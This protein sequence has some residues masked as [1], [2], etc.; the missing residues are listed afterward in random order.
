MIV[1]TKKEILEKKVGLCKK[2]QFVCEDCHQTFIMQARSVIGTH[3]ESLDSPLLCQKCKTNRTRTEREGPDWAVK[4]TKKIFDKLKEE[5]GVSNIAQRPDVK[6]KIT[7]TFMERYGVDCVMKTEGFKEKTRAY[8]EENQE[9]ISEKIRETL[10]ERYGVTCALNL[11]KDFSVSKETIEKRKKTC[12]ERYGGN[13]PVSSKEV[14]KKGEK[15]CLERYGARNITQ[16]ELW[17]KVRYHRFNYDGEFFDSSWELAFWI[18]YRDHGKKIERNSKR[19]LLDNGHF[20]FP[21][22]ITEEGLVEIKGNHLKKDE[23]FQFKMK[24][25]EKENVKLLFFSDI[26]PYIRYVLENYPPEFSKEYKLARYRR[27]VYDN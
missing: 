8:R 5:Y 9:E 1:K 20:C 7:D 17:D 23:N 11:R 27:K 14:R 19:Y 12:N 4:H 21:D 24:L 6:K 18:Y 13:A 3:H 16:S 22:F 26:K 2:V 25:Y 15:T 10:S